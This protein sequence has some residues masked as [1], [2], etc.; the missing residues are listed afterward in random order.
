MPRSS[1]PAQSEARI[2]EIPSEAP[3]RAQSVSV[4][5][6]LSRNNSK[7]STTTPAPFIPN[8][9][10]KGKNK[11]LQKETERERL[12]Q[13]Q[14]QQ[15]REHE[16]ERALQMERDM[17]REEAIEKQR[18][19]EQ[20]RAVER[21]RERAY[22]ERK[23]KGRNIVDLASINNKTESPRSKLSS[24]S[25]AAINTP[26]RRTDSI[27]SEDGSDD[28]PGLPSVPRFIPPS[29]SAN[30]GDPTPGSASLYDDIAGV[31]TALNNIMVKAS[32]GSYMQ[33]QVESAINV[34]NGAARAAIEESARRAQESI[35]NVLR[36]IGPQVPGQSV[37]VEHGRVRPVGT[38]P[39]PA[40]NILP[41]ENPYIRAR[42]T[43]TGPPRS[44]SMFPEQNTP[45]QAPRPF[46]APPTEEPPF[47]STIGLDTRIPPPFIPTAFTPGTPL[48]NTPGQQQMRGLFNS[49]PGPENQPMPRP[50]NHERT[51]FTG[52]RFNPAV[53]PH[54]HARPTEP[55][56][57]G[58]EP[59][60]AAPPSPRQTGEEQLAVQAEKERL[61][62]ARRSYKQEKANFRAQK[63]AE[64]LE[65]AERKAR[66][67]KG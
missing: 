6:N 58:G 65:R 46:A 15:D 19:A 20:E 26:A 56:F 27:S 22:A 43:N 59:I 36:T 37:I 41:M 55:L 16:R 4:E 47:R 61:E 17:E 53:G 1:S 38:T 35:A 10:G 2:E 12:Q 63:E 66:R 7:A 34:A 50:M 28:D 45:M 64:R 30:R 29:T 39:N 42:T 52:G 57:G 3:S 21:E 18:A 11:N 40:S 9:K 32:D 23:A 31:M 49:T 54:V 24:R 67:E 51:A 48:T 60:N 14:Q 44:W 8:I 5:D 33:T 13:Q 62:A 25:Q